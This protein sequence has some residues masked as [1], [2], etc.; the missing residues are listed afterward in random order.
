MKK[1]IH[2]ILPHPCETASRGLW[3]LFNAVTAAFGGFILV[4]GPFEAR[5]QTSVLAGLI[6]G[7]LAGGLWLRQ[8]FAAIRGDNRTARRWKFQLTTAPAAVPAS[9][10]GG[11]LPNFLPGGV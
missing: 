3:L 5:W 11:C 4:F 9:V 10:M 1:F 6:S 8:Q 2:W 7:L